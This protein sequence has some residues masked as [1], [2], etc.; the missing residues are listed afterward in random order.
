MAHKEVAHNVRALAVPDEK[1]DALANVDEIPEH[2][3][4]PGF[5]ADCV[6]DLESSDRIPFFATEP[7]EDTNRVSLAGKDTLPNDSIPDQ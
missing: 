3:Q 2:D 6:S 5:S 4:V 1:N 7:N